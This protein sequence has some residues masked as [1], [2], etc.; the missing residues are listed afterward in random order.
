MESARMNVTSSCPAVESQ[1]GEESLGPRRPSFTGMT[2]TRHQRR[3]DLRFQVQPPAKAA[4]IF[5][6]LNSNS[7]Q[8]LHVEKGS[9]NADPSLLSPR[10]TMPSTHKRDKPWDTDDI[11]KW[12]VC[13]PCLDSSPT[14][15]T[16]NR[17][18]NSSLATMPVALSQRSLPSLLSFPNIANSI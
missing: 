14:A 4:L 2:A 17:S 1:Y 16:A 15:D 3:R 6:I 7:G 11:D 10:N 18:R 9:C 5:T 13:V 8:F 12:K